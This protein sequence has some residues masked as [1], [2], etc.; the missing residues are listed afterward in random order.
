[1]F[2]AG[3]HTAAAISALPTAASFRAVP[4]AG[5]AGSA[6]AGAGAALTFNH[7]RRRPRARRCRAP[8]AAPRSSC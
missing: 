1:M 7:R 2:G 4:G 8:P 5:I 6:A 3:G